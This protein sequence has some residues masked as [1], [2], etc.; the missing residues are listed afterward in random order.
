[1]D[2]ASKFVRGDAIAGLIILIINLLGGIAIGVFMHSLSLGESFSRYAL[3]TIGDGL[4]AQVPSL[5]MSVAAA[6]IVTRMNDEGEMSDEVGR[7]LLAHQGC[8]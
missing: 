8:C 2:G 7:Q 5:L 1:M 3:L 6:I 4:V